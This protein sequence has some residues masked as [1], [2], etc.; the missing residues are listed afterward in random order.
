MIFER[1]F[2]LKFIEEGVMVSM[3]NTDIKNLLHAICTNLMLGFG[4]CF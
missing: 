3:Y 2:L 4:D 1:S